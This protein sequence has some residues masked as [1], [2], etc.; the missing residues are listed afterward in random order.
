M[1]L[2]A[3]L[4]ACMV[5]A[6]TA[7]VCAGA[8]PPDATGAPW[9]KMAAPWET[10]SAINDICAF[11]STGLAAAGDD[12]HIGITR[13][14]GRSWNVV[15][16]SGLEGAAFTAVAFNT[17]GRGAVVS[18]GV[19]LVTGDW[20]S[21]W[22]TPTYVGPGPGATI[23]D[24]AL[25]GSRA[26]AVGDEGVILTSDDAGASW[27]ETASPTLNHLSSVAIA[28]DGT[29]I[30]GSAAGE[31]LVATAGAWVVAGTAPGS[32]TSVAAAGDPAWGDG[33]PDLF[34]ATGSTVLGSD[35]ALAFASLPGLPDLSAH[36]WP[37]LAWTSVPVR[38]VLIVGG[39]DAGFFAPVD[40][41]WLS[42]PTGLN[43]AICAVSPG[44]QSVG[45]VLA[46]DGLART[47]S[48]GREPA[49]A[50]LTRSRIVFGG[51]TR[52]SAKV[53]VGAPGDVLLQQRVLGREWTTLRT[54]SWTAGDWERELSFD[55]KPSRTYQYRLDF[56]YGKAVVELAPA[57]TVVVAPRIATARSTYRL[58]VGDVYRFSGSVTPALPGARIILYTDRGGGWRPV[59]Q[60]GS[61]R[62]RSGRSWT[63]RRFG[64][65]VAE[66]Y[67][68]R[69]RLP[70]T[71][72]YGEAWSRVVTVT[73]R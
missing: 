66:T 20:G 22:R 71:R 15:T 59:S 1:C 16:P 46:A 13:D 7:A 39:P 3:V 52:L 4:C 41:S 31:I 55:L 63:S 18:G 5:A 23:V 32:V 6:C 27:R 47:L 48:A 45:Y 65:P 38:S 73:I 64:A 37:V 10:S 11:G 34:A 26:V 61:L 2:R 17:A 60:Q 58:R 72:T 70:A 35:D 49:T 57:S 21:T 9:S 67:H 28:G 29:A 43:G 42:A 33:R 69:A 62:L 12:G 14:G 30:A 68:L 24:V 40:R 56:R 8:I 50:Q 51:S 25:H 54:V 44:D 53:H 36:A 19:L